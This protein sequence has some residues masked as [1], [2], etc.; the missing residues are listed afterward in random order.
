MEFLSYKAGDIE[1][2]KQ[3]IE[4]IEKEKYS[5]NKDYCM[6]QSFIILNEIVSV[7]LKIID[8]CYKQVENT[9]FVL[10]TDFAITQLLNLLQA[11]T[12]EEIDYSYNGHSLFEGA[13]VSYQ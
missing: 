5:L 8:Q 7:V 12:A 10:M 3:F 1:R 11:L 6:T 4:K 2:R 9:N 13:P